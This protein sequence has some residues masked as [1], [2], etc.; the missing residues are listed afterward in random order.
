MLKPCFARTTFQHADADRLLAEKD[1]FRRYQGRL[2]S[3][4]GEAWP[5]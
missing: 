4:M 3:P 2:S 5:L 1:R